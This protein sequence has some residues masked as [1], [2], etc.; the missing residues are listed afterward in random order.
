MKKIAIILAAAAAFAACTKSEV[1]YDGPQEIGFAPATKNITKASGLSGTLATTQELGIWAYWD[2]DAT[3]G[4]V[5][6]YGGY[7][8]NYLVNALFVNKGA[9]WG[10]AGNGYPWPVNGALVFAGYTTPGDDVLASNKVSYDLGTDKMTFTAYENT[11]EFDLCWFGRTASSYNNRADGAA[12]SVNLSHALAWVSVAVCGEGSPVGNWTV[13]SMSMSNVATAG[14]AVC[15]GASLKATWTGKTVSEDPYPVFSGSQTIPA[16]TVVNGKTTGTV[17][18]D[19]VLIP[20]ESVQLTVNYSFVVN[21][22]T[23]TDSKTVTLNTAEWESG[24]HYTYTLFFQGN[25][26]LVSPS[27]NGWGSSDQTI[28]VQ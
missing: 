10:G 14:T 17:I 4:T 8:D 20:S 7:S 18:S 26:I 9:S 25:E 23:K 24:I 19:N 11:N 6:A 28:T 1:N 22:Q 21:G 16:A 12:V 2:N 15:D 13:T 5:S 27:Y 3:P